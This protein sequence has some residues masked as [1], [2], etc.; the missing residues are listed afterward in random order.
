LS[1]DENTRDEKST[2]QW[3]AMSLLDFWNLKEADSPAVNV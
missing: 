1:R 3:R 2:I